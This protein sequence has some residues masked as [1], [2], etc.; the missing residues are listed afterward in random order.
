MHNN[1]INELLG[2]KDV[3]VKKVESD[4]FSIT[5]HIETI[6][7]E[8]VCPCCNNT[9]SKVH[10]YRFQTIKDCPILFKNTFIK[11]RK[12]RYKCKNCGKQFF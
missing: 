1:Y 3:K 2:F 6:K 5:L 12:R 8:Q 10:D 7:K 4:D 9:T 11:L